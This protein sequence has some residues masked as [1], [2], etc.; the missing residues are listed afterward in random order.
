MFDEEIQSPVYCRRRGRA[1]V[2]FQDIQD[3][4]GPDRFMTVPDKFQYPAAQRSQAHALA[5]TKL[6]RPVQGIGNAMIVVMVP[7]PF[8]QWHGAVIGGHNFLPGL[9]RFVI[10]GCYTVT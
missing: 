2:V 5:G 10:D 4:V 7:R 6:L 3:G 8:I 1:L 9:T